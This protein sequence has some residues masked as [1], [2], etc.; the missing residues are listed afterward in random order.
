MKHT[1]LL[2]KLSCLILLSGAFYFISCKREYADGMD[3]TI[4][5]L[6]GT[7]VSGTVAGSQ[8]FPAGAS[9]TIGILNGSYNAATNVLQYTIN[10]KGLSSSASEVTINGLDR[11][12]SNTTLF[13]LQITVPGVN[14]T[15]TGT[16]SLYEAQ[17]DGLLRGRWDYI[18]HN[19]SFVDGELRGQIKVSPY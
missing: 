10:W 4:Y 16:V 2:K 17:E 9:N 3:R 13:K 12:G 19:S 7:A 11:N 5:T 8:Q 14:G 18:I 15:A 1:G 6:S